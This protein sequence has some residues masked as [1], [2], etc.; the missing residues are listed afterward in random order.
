MQFNKETPIYIQIKDVVYNAILS[1][2]YCGGERIP[3]IRDMAVSLEVNPNTVTRTY[4]ILQEEGVIENQRGLG[5]FAVENA[6]DVVLNQM[7]DEFLTVEVPLFFSKM[8][9][10]GIP[11]EKIT[12]LYSEPKKWR[13]T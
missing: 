5:Y 9:R 3:S 10:L 4:A 6:K 13:K 1:G 11:M 12:T 8:E 7:K 2:E